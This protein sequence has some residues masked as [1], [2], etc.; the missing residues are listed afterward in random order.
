MFFSSKGVEREWENEETHVGG[1][2]SGR[3]AR[4]GRKRQSGGK[5]E[6]AGGGVL[7]CCLS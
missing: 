7:N 1:G 5:G 2:E 3:Q 6:R 4:N